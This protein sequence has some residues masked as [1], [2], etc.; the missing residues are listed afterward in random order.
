MNHSTNG[1]NE[2]SARCEANL[3]LNK[4]AVYGRYEFVQKSSGELDL[5]SEFGDVD[6]NIN[7]FKLG[8]NR[9][10][11]GCSYVQFAA[12]AQA[13]VNVSPHELQGLYGKTPIGGE[14]YLQL[15]PS[16]HSHQ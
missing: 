12:G 15:K 10:I 6:I 13:T 8:Y 2:H 5:E 9:R 3:Q 1:H 16:K 4:Q 7:I 14:V 11:W